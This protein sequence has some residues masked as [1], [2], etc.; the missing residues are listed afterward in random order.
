M[1]RIPSIGV[2]AMILLVSSHAIAQT[3][4]HAIPAPPA[5]AGAAPARPLL[6]GTRG[7]AFAAIQGNAL[8]STN[9]QLADS[10][11]RLRDAR[12]GRIL[13]VQVTDKSGLFAFKTVDPGTYVVELV[14]NDQPV[15]AASE[16]L[17]V[18]A[19]EAL[20]AVVKL[21]WRAPPLAGILGHTVPSA[22]V[23][24]AAAAA[25]GVLAATVTGTAACDLPTTA[26]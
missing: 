3:P 16:L 20:S 11:V 26:R 15:L 5:S 23:I 2:V 6:A 12:T 14:G 17:D 25:S 7:N 4:A 24:S 21:P 1:H 8:T 18:N 9:G 10:L 19:G 22:L 13:D